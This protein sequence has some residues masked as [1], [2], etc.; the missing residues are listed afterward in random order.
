MADFDEV[1][2]VVRLYP[3]TGDERWVMEP[4][5]DCPTIA[6]H[7][8]YEYWEP[9]DEVWV[10]APELSLS[11]FPAKVLAMFAENLDKVKGN[12]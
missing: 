1:E 12:G 10:K 11:T 5:P 7:I 8:F 9:E 4:D 6:V 3:Q 2:T